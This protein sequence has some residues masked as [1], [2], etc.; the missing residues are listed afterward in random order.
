MNGFTDAPSIRPD[1]TTWNV[2]WTV[3]FQIRSFSGRFIFLHLSTSP[4]SDFPGSH[5]V[6]KHEGTC[7]VLNALTTKFWYFL[8]F[9]SWHMETLQWAWNVW[10]ELTNVTRWHPFFILSIPL[11]TFSYPNFFRYLFVLTNF[12]SSRRY[13]HTTIP[14]TGTLIL[15][16]KMTSLDAIFCRGNKSSF[17]SHA[18]FRRRKHKKIYHSHFVLMKKFKLDL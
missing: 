8:C 17:R 13:M 16:A 18:R 4:R 10:S 1:H 14:A 7:F 15:Y 11:F 2:T 5:G 12:D 3:L 9:L 6:K